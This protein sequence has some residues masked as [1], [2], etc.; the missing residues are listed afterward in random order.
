MFTTLP[1]SI[2]NIWQI[3]LLA[4][5]VVWFWLVWFVGFLWFRGWF[6]THYANAG[7]ICP[8]LMIVTFNCN[9]ITVLILWFVTIKTL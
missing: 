1:V 3:G 4:L 5:S 7:V 9:P 8:P 2:F 6:W